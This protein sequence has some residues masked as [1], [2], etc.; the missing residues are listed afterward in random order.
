T[1]LALVVRDVFTGPRLIPANSL[2]ESAA[3]LGLVLGPGGAG[4]LA[5]AGLLRASLLID[6]VTFLVSLACLAGLR[7]CYPAGP[8]PPRPALTWRAAPSELA[9]GILQVAGIRVLL[10]RLLFQL[11]LN[12]RLGASKLV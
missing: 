3:Q 11:A 7:G 10:T 1:A 8:R 12:P 6:A 4:L 9:D 2:L 5:T